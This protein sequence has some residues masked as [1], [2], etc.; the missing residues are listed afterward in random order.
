MDKLCN[1]FWNLQAEILGDNSSE[2]LGQV[3]SRKQF[4]TRNVFGI[5][6]P[7]Y[8]RAWWDITKRLHGDVV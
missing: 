2:C 5:I 4:L 8:I 7:V 3:L 1:V 6:I